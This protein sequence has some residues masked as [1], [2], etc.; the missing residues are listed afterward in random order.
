MK[1]PI[2]TLVAVSLSAPSFAESIWV[3]AE[4]ATVKSIQNNGWYS[5]VKNEDLSGGGLLAHWGNQAGSAQYQIKVPKSGDYVLWLRAN[6]VATKLQ[7]KIAGGEWS[8]LQIKGQSHEQINLAVDNKPDL[9]FVSWIRAGVQNLKA[10][11]REVEIRFTSDNNNHGMLDCFCLT[12]D[13]NWKPGGILQPGEDQTHWSVPELT[14]ANLDE[15]L[16]FIRPSAEELGWRALRWHSSLSEAAEEAKA[17]QRPIL[18]WAMNGHP[19]G[20]T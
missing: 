20:E 10:G 19:C 11:E 1:V 7:F 17:L 3:E 12:S 4:S 14:E 2:S 16:Q 8:D 9:R 5:S 15:W 13:T 6:P 18:L